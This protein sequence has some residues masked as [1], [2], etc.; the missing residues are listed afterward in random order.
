MPANLAIRAF[1]IL[2]NEGARSLAHS[3]KRFARR[4]TEHF[5][6]DIDRHIDKRKYKESYP[7][8]DKL[9]YANPE[10]V[11]YYQLE[12]K[13]TDWNYREKIEEEVAHLYEMDKAGFRRRINAGRII[14]GNWDKQK[15]EWSEHGLYNSLKHIYQE[16][17]NW[18]ETEFIKLCLNRIEKGYSSYGYETKEEFLNNRI[19][20]IEN[21]YESIREEGYQRQDQAP[22]DH[23][24][25]D[26][27]HEVSVNIGR[28]GELIFNNRSGQHRLSL[29]RILNI[30]EIPMIVIVRHKKWQEVRK[31]IHESNTISELSPKAKENITHPDVQDVISNEMIQSTAD[32]DLP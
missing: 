5:K 7:S 20:Y 30:E 22:A 9:I 15:R 32:H 29:S 1:E 10:K 2:R 19:P 16:G 14:G 12:S 17:G 11:E 3:T 27:F 28:D 21:L 18:E 25:K 6:Y 13:E 24:N 8:R 31:E 4:R 26:I 23:R